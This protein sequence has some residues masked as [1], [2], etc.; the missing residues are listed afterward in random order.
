MLSRQN[1]IAATPPR[2]TDLPGEVLARV[3]QGSEASML[4]MKMV[5]AGA[6]SDTI[7]QAQSLRALDG[8][9][10]ANASGFSR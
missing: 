10:T 7:R 8:V 3:G 2:P 1:I 5:I 4:E 9:Q 6:A